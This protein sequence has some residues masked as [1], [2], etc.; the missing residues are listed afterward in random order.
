VAI[1]PQGLNIVV[2]STNGA[3]GEYSAKPSR[4]VPIVIGVH[5]EAA[6]EGVVVAAE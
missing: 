6:E 1:E 5:R 2:R 3:M 4:F